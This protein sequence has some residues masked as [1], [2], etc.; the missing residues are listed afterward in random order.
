MNI[1][2]LNRKEMKKNMPRFDKT[3]PQGKG[4]KTGRGT[5]PCNEDQ[6]KST[7]FGRIRRGFLSRKA[8]K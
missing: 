1:Y 2:S 6:S 7:D 5:G 3:G 4:P 8:G